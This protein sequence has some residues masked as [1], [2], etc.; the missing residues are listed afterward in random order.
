MRRLV[1]LLVTAL[2]ALGMGALAAPVDAAP[3]VAGRNAA[4]GLLYPGSS[5]YPRLIRLG[6]SGNANGTIVASVNTLQQTGVILA[7][8]D[9]GKTFQQ[10]ATIVDPVTTDVTARRL[11]CS[12]LMELPLAVG[13][14]PE[15]TLLWAD[16]TYFDILNV[17]RHVEQRLWA[18]T[19][20]GFHW[21]YVS[22]IESADTFFSLADW[23]PRLPAA[24]EPSLSVAGD[25]ELV[26]YY[27]DETD[28]LAHS[29]K[30]VQVRS[31]DAIH[32][33][34][35]ADTVVSDVPDV[36]PG[37][38]NAIQL[39]DG[40]YFMTYE[41]CNTD[42]IHPC[43]IYFRRS[44]DGW[45]YGDPRF[46]GTMVRTAA[47]NGYTQHTPYPVWS[48]TPAPHGTILLSG[49]M[50]SNIAGQQTPYSGHDI[51]ANNNLGNGL[52]YEI[53]APIPIADIVDAPCKNYSSPLLPSADGTSVLEAATDLDQGVCRSYYATGPLHR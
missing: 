27:S 24:W 42:M 20:H 25:G 35:K 1:V 53:P 3:H 46:L 18:S 48:P 29:Q 47:G 16:T 49:Q 43:L 13:T 52:W 11:C 23:G 31:P 4:R 34:D 30:L 9:G 28:S 36:R 22:S 32:W 45:N 51:L 39:P 10:R 26:A 7:S 40:S 41:I 6:H 37:M 5:F 50:Q 8:T 19:D 12:S 21:Q 2:T 17:V 14:L 44:A 33:V 15:G 38:A